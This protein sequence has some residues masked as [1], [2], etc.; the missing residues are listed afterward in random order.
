MPLK[1]EK[2]EKEKKFMANIVIIFNNLALVPNK[3]R[4]FPAIQL[5]LPP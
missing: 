2:K 4:Q 5:T 3:D 1:N